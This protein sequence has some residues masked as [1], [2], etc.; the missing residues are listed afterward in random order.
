MMNN[1]V[2]KHL[3]LLTQLFP[4]EDTALSLVWVKMEVCYHASAILLL[5]WWK[6]KKLL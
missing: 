5:S 4:G 6:E 2:L 1:F 3:F